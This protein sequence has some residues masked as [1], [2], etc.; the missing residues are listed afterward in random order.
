MCP[1]SQLYSARTAFSAARK[2]GVAPDGMI[3]KS[4]SR[5]LGQVFGVVV[6]LL[7][8]SSP[9]LLAVQSIGLPDV[10]CNGLHSTLTS[11][12]FWVTQAAT[13]HGILREDCLRTSLGCFFL[14]MQS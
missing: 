11:W 1:A 12:P 9:L 4:T 2:V 5:Y 8:I 10:S 6:R 3:H 7:A 13:S 14:L